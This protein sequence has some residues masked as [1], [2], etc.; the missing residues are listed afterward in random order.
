MLRVYGR[1]HERERAWRFGWACL[2][3][4]LALTPIMIAIL[5]SWEGIVEVRMLLSPK[6]PLSTQC[7]AMQCRAGMERK[8]K[9]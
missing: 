3:G 9:C 1:T 2:G 6:N 8:C 7:C 4:S 5:G